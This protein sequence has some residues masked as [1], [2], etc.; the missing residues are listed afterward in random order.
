MTKN[1]AGDNLKR[2]RLHFVVPDKYILIAL[3]AACFAPC[4]LTAQTIAGG[5]A[6]IAAAGSGAVLEQDI[7]DWQAA[8][9]CYGPEAIT[10][11]KAGFMRLFEA[12]IL[13]EVLNLAARPITPEE[14]SKEAARIDAETRAPEILA[15]I[16]KHFGDDTYR[17]G[18]VFVRP[19]LAQRFIREFVKSDPGVQA[20]AYS[21][22]GKIS[23]EAAK[24]TR[25]GDIASSAGVKYSTAV[26]SLEADTAAAAA[27]EPWNRWSPFE[28][29]F[30][31]EHLKD[32]RPGSAKP[33]PIEDELNIKF[34]KLI[35]VTGKKYYFESLTIPKIST[36]EYLK[37][38]P[39]IL[40]RIFDKEL[41]DWAAPI[42]GNPI[43]APA[44]IVSETKA[45]K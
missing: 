3:L 24:G 43:L 23:A 44:E 4:R 14:Y 38:I 9:G 35:G 12:A 26:Y 30:I 19:I 36:E 40:C 21:L 45:G 1:E 10:S 41:R 37:D 33:Q 22:R 8:Q 18:R 2:S 17:Y 31:E 11:R 29:A 32:L 34:V 5:P 15:C 42:K 16:K 28:A 27:A 7:L 20:R 6:V 39:K 25:F 13:N